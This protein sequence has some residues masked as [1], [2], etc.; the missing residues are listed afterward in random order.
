MHENETEYDY[1]YKI[2]MKGFYGEEGSG[3]SSLLAQYAQSKSEVTA[4]G[5]MGVE[6]ASKTI[7]RVK[8]QIWDIAS[9]LQN[10]S[11][12]KGALAFIYVYSIP[13]EQNF[14]ELQGEIDRLKERGILPEICPICLLGNKNDLE[15]ERRVS[16]EE[17]KEFAQKNGLLF[18][19]EVSAKTGEGVEAAFQRVTEEIQERQRL[20]NEERKRPQEQ[21]EKEL[22]ETKESASLWL[23][24]MA[25][26]YKPWVAG[27]ITIAGVAALTTGASGV[28]GLISAF[29]DLASKALIVGGAAASMTGLCFF[30][31]GYGSDK[32][33]KLPVPGFPGPG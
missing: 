29:S 6:F 17:M 12:T 10:P 24:L 23:N 5:G 14:A 4:P 30:A 31:T 3:S 25:Y 15:V 11:Y 2:C 28:F 26:S 32:Q 20:M 21:E 7:N 22:R 16:K 9:R 1:L 19:G 27:I 33:E 18:L 13:A 8:L